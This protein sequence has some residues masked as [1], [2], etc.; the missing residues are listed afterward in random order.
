M[1]LLGKLMARMEVMICCVLLDDGSVLGIFWLI[2]GGGRKEELWLPPKVQ[3]A[4]GTTAWKG[5]C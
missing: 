2:W 1:G 5:K 3:E 4:N